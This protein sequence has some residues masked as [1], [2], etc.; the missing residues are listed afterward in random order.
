MTREESPGQLCFFSWVKRRWEVAAELTAAHKDLKESYKM[1]KSI[2][3][4]WCQTTQEGRNCKFLFER[5]GMP[6]RKSLF[7]ISGEC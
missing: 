1:T 4:W 7:F 5:L 2:S 6:I 3:S